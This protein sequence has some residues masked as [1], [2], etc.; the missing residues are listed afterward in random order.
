LSKPGKQPWMTAGNN[1]MILI[2]IH[3]Y[4]NIV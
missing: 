1:I 2:H 3:A 4:I